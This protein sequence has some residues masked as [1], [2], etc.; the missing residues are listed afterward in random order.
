MANVT[1]S[2]KISAA[3]FRRL[4]A[5]LPKGIEHKDLG[6]GCKTEMM[7]VLNMSWPVKR[8]ISSRDRLGNL[9]VV[10]EGMQDRL[11]KKYLRVVAK[12][13]E[14]AAVVLTAGETPELLGE[15]FYQD[16]L[17]LG[18]GDEVHS[19]WLSALMHHLREGLI[20]Q[21][22][23]AEVVKAYDR[24]GDPILLAEWDEIEYNV[25][26]H[27]EECDRIFALMKTIQRTVEVLEEL[28]RV[29][30]DGVAAMRAKWMHRQF[31][32]QSPVIVEA[33]EALLAELCAQLE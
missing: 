16:R 26:T 13:I 20:F 2:G 22:R 9:V 32:W 24:V 19:L 31:L 30:Q 3:D 4:R 15:F 25:F 27:D 23:A 5:A 8:R 6:D 11:D 10:T 29:G 28:Y 14:K 1:I 7:R 17:E 21:S 33:N 12:H 18:S